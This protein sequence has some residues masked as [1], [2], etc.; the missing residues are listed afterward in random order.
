MIF[1]KAGQSVIFTIYYTQETEDQ[2]QQSESLVETWGGFF[3]PA[4]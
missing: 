4:C 2:R 3:I 1:F